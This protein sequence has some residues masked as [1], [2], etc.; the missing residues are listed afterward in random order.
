MSSLT[1]IKAGEKFVPREGAYNRFCEVAEQFMPGTG[2]PPIDGRE[3]GPRLVARVKN[4]TGAQIAFGACVMLDENPSSLSIYPGSNGYEI[5]NSPG[6]SAV[7]RSSTSTTMFPQRFG[8]ALEP[9]AAGEIGRVCVRGL[10]VALGSASSGWLMPTFTSSSSGFTATTKRTSVNVL[11]A[12]SDGFAVVYLDEAPWQTRRSSTGA[13]S[14][15]TSAVRGQTY[16]GGSDADGFTYTGSGGLMSGSIIKVPASGIYDIRYNL[17][18][19]LVLNG[20]TLPSG[21]TGAFPFHV[22]NIII[23]ARIV[24][25]DSGGSLLGAF[26]WPIVNS[27]YGNLICA[28]LLYEHSGGVGYGCAPFTYGSTTLETRTALYSNVAL[29]VGVALQVSSFSGPS[30]SITV[31]GTG[32][33]RPAEQDIYVA[34]P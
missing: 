30:Y 25:V 8:V 3:D 20:G 9:I 28:P 22:N 29:S 26:N 13:P 4:N 17:H 11:H 7:F 24:F 33:I 19:E 14:T 16:G 18:A 5:N 6:F 10:C 2:G 23:T 1:R 31:R 34:P 15:V 32:I 27:N 12:M 21:I